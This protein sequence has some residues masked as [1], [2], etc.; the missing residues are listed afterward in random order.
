MKQYL[1]LCFSLLIFYS[2]KKDF[3]ATFR[4][5]IVFSC[6]NTPVG[7]LR[8]SIQRWDGHDLYEV[9]ATNTDENGYY[10]ISDQINNFGKHDYFELHTYGFTQDS[11]PAWP[12]FVGTLANSGSSS[13][14]VIMNASIPYCQKIILH[15]KNVNPHTADDKFKWIEQINYGEDTTYN[16]IA[17]DYLVGLVDTN[18]SITTAETNPMHFSFAYEKDGITTVVDTNIVI[19]PCYDIYTANIFY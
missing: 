3:E 17:N 10:S 9:C 18:F 7:G 12:C 16:I 4:G 13:K 6:D 5:R 19:S 11:I 2:C 14:T 8:L 15:V 1:L